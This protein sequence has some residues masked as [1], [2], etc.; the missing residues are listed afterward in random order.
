MTR[1]TEELARKLDSL[2]LWGALDGHNWALKPS[3]TVMP[4][5]CTV[6]PSDGDVKSR[7][8]FIEGWQNFHFHVALKAD[9]WFGYL[10][11]PLEISHYELII[12]KSGTMLLAR[13]DACF[14]PRTAREDE[15]PFVRKLL[16]Q[17]YGVLLRLESDK[18]LMMKYARE[19]ALFARIETGPDEWEDSPLPIQPFHPIVERV[20]VPAKIAQGVKDL[21]VDS[22]RILAAEMRIAPNLATKGE[23]PR[24]GYVFAV[25]DVK[26]RRRAHVEI[27]AADASSGGVKGLWESLAPKLL[28]WF[29]QDKAVPSE[30]QLVS[31]RLFRYLRPICLTLPVR[32][33]LHD[34]IDGLN[35]IF[36]D[37]GPVQ[38]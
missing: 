35:A 8:L 3:G 28:S 36:A 9:R 34:G 24:M 17:T 26:T 15:E 33:S 32:L 23:R 6:M 25:M 1:Q 5:F 4:Y 38:P 18:S 20:S 7:L 11:S 21:P 27:M 30:I 22:G 19:Q 13:Y 2:G 10:S 31:G 29:V 12:A 16:W 14:F 37:T